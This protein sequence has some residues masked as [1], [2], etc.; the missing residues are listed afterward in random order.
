MTIAPVAVTISV[1]VTVGVVTPR[2]LQAVSTAAFA[3][4]CVVA[5]TL[6]TVVVDVSVALTVLTVNSVLVTVTVPLPFLVT[7]LASTVVVP[8]GSGVA[9]ETTML[10]AWIYV[11][12]IVVVDVNVTVEGV[13]DRYE[14]QNL[15]RVVKA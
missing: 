10:P 5:Q 9:V 15:S 13:I 7:G 1:D 2:Q 11:K 14:V 12:G 8:G 4:T 3:A 6:P